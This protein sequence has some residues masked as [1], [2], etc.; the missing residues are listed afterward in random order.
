MPRDFYDG[1]ADRSVIGEMKRLRKAGKI[2]QDGDNV[3]TLRL[4]L[5]AAGR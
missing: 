4:R 2:V 3:H 5:V 1:S